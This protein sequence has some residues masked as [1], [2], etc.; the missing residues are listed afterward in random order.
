MRILDLRCAECG[1]EEIDV[2]ITG[3]IYP[4]CGCG[5]EMKF[6]PSKLN[7]DVWG[8]PTYFK[9]LDMTFDS[10]SDLKRHLKENDLS[11]CGDRVGGARTEDH[12]RCGKTLYFDQKE[13]KDL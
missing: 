2:C 8:G 6:L 13:A 3:D 10:K 1:N 4:P 12:L 5:G 7:S 9:S 11:E